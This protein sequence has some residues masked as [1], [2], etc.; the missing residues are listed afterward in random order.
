MKLIKHLWTIW[1]C[2][3]TP[4]GVRGLKYLCDLVE[5]FASIRRTPHGVRGLKYAGFPVECF[6]DGRTPH[7]VRGLKCFRN[8][9]LHRHYHVAPRTGCVD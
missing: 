9:K 5:D 7:G 8:E 2:C 1:Q 6:D 4:H 3:R